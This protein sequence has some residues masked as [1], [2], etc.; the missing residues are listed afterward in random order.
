MQIDLERVL[1]EENLDA[2]ALNASYS[3]FD[4]NQSASAVNFV[5]LP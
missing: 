3:F 2:G 4:E 5:G 1:E